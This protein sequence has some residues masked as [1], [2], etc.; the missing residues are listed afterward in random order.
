MAK[1]SNMHHLR[2]SLLIELA[3]LLIAFTG[4]LV[5]RAQSTSSRFKN[6]ADSMV[7]VNSHLSKWH[8]YGGLHVSGDAEMYY[9]GPSFQAGVDYNLTRRLAL[10]TYVHYF[11]AS[12]DLRDNTGAVEK[13]Q[14]KTFTS[15]LLFQVDMGA[16]W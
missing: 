16:G 9:G 5:T 1:A 15:T 6:A 12:S 4:P 8:P 14:F 10:S 2:K 7:I 3:L 13:G 11:H